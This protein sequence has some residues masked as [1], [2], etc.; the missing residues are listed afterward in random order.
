MGAKALPISVWMLQQL[1]GAANQHWQCHNGE[2]SQVS[3]YHFGCAGEAEPGKGC[4]NCQ[5][6][7]TVKLLL[8]IPRAGAKLRGSPFER[9]FRCWPRVAIA[10]TLVGHWL[11]S[12][13]RRCSRALQL[14]GPPATAASPLR[15]SLTAGQPSDACSA[16]PVWRRQS[17]CAIG[18]AARQA[19]E[20]IALRR[21]RGPPAAPAA[22][23]C[24]TATHRGSPFE[25]ALLAPSGEDTR[26]SGTLALQHVRPRN[27]ALQL[28]ARASCYRR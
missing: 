7:K 16:G 9:A 18:S 22:I 8:G 10:L 11:C 23:P 21:L 3:K 28:H 26:N 20:A 4:F 25:C 15:D 24:A 12:T 27:R 13:S 17:R 5:S 14:R 19:V 6:I 2:F 1:S